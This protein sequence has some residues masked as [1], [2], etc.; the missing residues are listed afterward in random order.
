[1]QRETHTPPILVVGGT[2]TVG[3]ELVAQLTE[4]SYPVR[5][6]TR[7]PRR[8]AKFEHAVEVFCGD[9]DDQQSLLAPMHG[10]ERMFLITAATQ[11]DRNALSAAHAAGV[12]HVVKLSTQEAGWTPVEGHGHW[13]KEREDLIRAST[14]TWTFLRPCM[15]MDFA[16]SWAQG[17]R[18]DGTI[19]TAGGEGKLAPVDPYDVAAVA[20]SALTSTGHENAAYELTG[21][22]L[23]TFGDMASALSVVLG[24]PVRHMPMSD[25]DQAAV[26]SRMGLPK[27]A[28]DGLVETFSLIRK[29]RFAY[30]TDDVQKV[31]GRVPRTF[32]KWCRNHA[33]DF[34]I[35][36]AE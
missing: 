26:F 12:R 10:V 8:A 24:R 21:P 1:M 4:D 23:L 17:I 18:V 5:V 11:Q 9:L 34:G 13:H 27:H 7:H 28:V 6:L 32:D 35:Q 19:R 2:G 25:A 30:L 20:K 14:L 3:T 15:F 33:G 31:T 36:G 22:E 16:L 29:G